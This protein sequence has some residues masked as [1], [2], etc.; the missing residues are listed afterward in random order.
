MEDTIFAAAL[1]LFFATQIFTVVLVIYAWRRGMPSINRELRRQEDARIREMA[2]LPELPPHLQPS[3]NRFWMFA[4]A[5][6]GVWP[7]ALIAWS[8]A[9]WI[10]IA[11][12]VILTVLIAVALNHEPARLR[13][14][15]EK[16]RSELRG[17]HSEF[18]E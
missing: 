16:V 14:K 9:N 3:N 10:G 1:V 7:F 18:E 12:L 8:L 17:H 2:E 13:A 15:I 5:S 6:L 4:V 11:A